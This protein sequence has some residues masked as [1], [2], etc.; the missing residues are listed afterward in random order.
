[1]SF[2]TYHRAALIGAIVTSGIAL[3]D[4]V[5]HGVTGHYSAFAD[6]SDLPWVTFLGGLAHGLTYVALAVV[7]LREGP[8][9]R[10][11]NR[12]ARAARWVVLPSLAVL[13]PG[14][15]FVA[16][17]L[18]FAEVD[19]GVAYTTWGGVA[20]F[21]F[22]GMILGS[23]VLGLALLRDRSLGIGARVLS[24]MVP[25]LG[26]TFLLVWLAPAWGHP[27]YLE[28]TLHFGLALLGVSATK[29][30]VAAPRSA[31]AERRT[32]SSVR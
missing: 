25:V 6:D 29:E 11:T 17:V 8:R 4:A 18:T 13:A 27:A 20:G 2:S 24:L 7:L 5:T 32:E 10:D 26:A 3:T 9:F 12:I 15:L 16:P 28:A 14:F 21:A 30:L 22:V 31:P 19:G 23:L 1:M